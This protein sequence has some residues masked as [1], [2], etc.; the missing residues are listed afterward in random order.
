MVG[1]LRWAVEL[2]RIDVHFHVSIMSR[3]L[4]APREGH[5]EQVLHIFAY[6]KKHP[7]Y[8]LVMDS[9]PVNWKDEKFPIGDWTDFYPDAEEDIPITYRK[10]FILPIYRLAVHDYLVT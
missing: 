4:A 2:G 9:Q 8:K 3:Y 1:V 5:L 6:L 10:L 7:S